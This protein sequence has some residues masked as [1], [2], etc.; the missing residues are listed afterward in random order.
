M[1]NIKVEINKSIGN[2]FIGLLSVYKPTESGL[3]LF[4]TSFY[5]TGKSNIEVLNLLLEKLT[6]HYEPSF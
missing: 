5:V 2:V 4:V 6:N 1:D 3:P